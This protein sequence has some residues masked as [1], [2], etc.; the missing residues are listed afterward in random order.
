MKR[1]IPSRRASKSARPTTNATRAEPAKRAQPASN[2]KKNELATNAKSS[3]DPRPARTNGSSRGNRK[4]GNNGPRKP[5]PRE[6]ARARAVDLAMRRATPLPWSAPKPPEDDPEAAE[7]IARIMASQSYRRADQD[8]DFMELDELRGERLEL[9]YLKPDIVLRRHQVRSTVV[10]FGSTRLV[11]PAAALRR[12]EAARRDL[13]RAPTDPEA[14]RR[15]A[16]AERV[17]ALSRY[18]DESRELARIVSTVCQ[19]G[20]PYQ[21][22][23]MTGGGPGIMEAA[24]RG[25]FDVGAKSVGLNINLPHE[26]YPNPYITPELCFQFRYFALRKM[27]FMR[28]A[29]AL[30]AFP[31]GYG[32]FDEVFDALCLI[33][34]Q[35]IPPLPVILVGR[36]F[37][38]RAFD[39]EFL[40]SEGVIDAEDVHL[41]TYA[42]TAQEAW[43]RIVDFWRGFGEP[44]IP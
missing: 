9:E 24:N 6:L 13:D 1:H 14:Q 2:G 30:V 32:T 18:Y 39:P 7:R 4:N 15:V 41:F 12:L 31:G 38:K 43:E 21:F 11:E 16:V 19:Q 20:G 27:H 36:E 34:T 44:V 26:Q 3:T 37:W 40:A 5:T 33:Q 17:K 22:V 23:V 42:E 8:P 29:R 10:V 28:L 35:K 25:A